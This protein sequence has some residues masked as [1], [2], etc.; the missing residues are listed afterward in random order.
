MII[1]TR[2]RSFFQTVT[3]H[4]G[5]A[6]LIGYF[7]FQGYNGQYGLLARRH[8]EQELADLTAQRDDIRSRREALEAKVALLSPERIDAD[9]LDEEA[10][11]LLNL[12]N[13]KDLVLLRTPGTTARPE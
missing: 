6:A 5:A 7:A 13:P 12:V 1:R 9:T 8:F 4:L 2:W 11:A 10:R 3:L